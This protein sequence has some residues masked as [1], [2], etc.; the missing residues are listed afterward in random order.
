M[1]KGKMKHKIARWKKRLA[2]I[3]GA[4]HIENLKRSGKWKAMRIKGGW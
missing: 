2:M 4:W 1:A 3:R